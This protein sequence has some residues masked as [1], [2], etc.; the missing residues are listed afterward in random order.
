MDPADVPLVIVSELPAEETLEPWSGYLDAGGTVLAVLATPAA[1]PA[2]PAVG[3]EQPGLAWLRALLGAPSL[4]LD[5]AEVR[6][7]AMLGEV[8]F[9]HPLFAP[10]ADP[11][12]ADFT[13]VHFWRHRRIGA[14]A[15]LTTLARFD[16]GDAFLLERKV[17]AGRLYV[18]TSGWQPAD[19][20]L[21]RSSK[22]PPLMIGMLETT[23][24][25]GRSVASHYLVGEPVPLEGA[26]AG[27]LLGVVRPD[28]SEFRVPS[29]AAAF[30]ETDRP[31]IYELRFADR[32]IPFAVNLDP[33]ESRTA[34]LDVAELEQRGARIAVPLESSGPAE[35]QA[36]G[37]ELESRQK[38]WRWL[39]AAALAVLVVETWLAG[40][41]GRRRAEVVA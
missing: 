25:P 32:S 14:P 11:R 36:M 15:E 7:Y 6:D 29:G 41:L 20:E 39:L 34:P 27:G 10:F 35:R 38:L 16:D 19:S 21:G 37:V 17:A 8:D 28:G 4:S 3:V 5:E 12:F 2:E 26:G 33:A 18:M 30:E 13:A 23:P 9:D 31:G 40:H 22:F 24:R 1:A